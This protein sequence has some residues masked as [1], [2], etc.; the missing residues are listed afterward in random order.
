MVIKDFL[1]AI[2]NSHLKDFFAKDCRRWKLEVI[3]VVSL[4]IDLSINVM[5]GL[6][7]PS[8]YLK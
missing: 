8:I 5:R 7:K 2:E 6:R 1:R 4:L 3:I